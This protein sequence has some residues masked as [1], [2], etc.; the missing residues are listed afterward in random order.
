MSTAKRRT[1]CAGTL[2]TAVSQRISKIFS[3]G[4]WQTL[5]VCPS[6]SFCLLSSCT[7]L[8]PRFLC[9]CK[10]NNCN[11]PH[12]QSAQLQAPSLKICQR[13][14]SL[15][16]ISLQKTRDATT[17]AAWQSLPQSTVFTKDTNNLASVTRWTFYNLDPFDIFWAQTLWC[18]AFS[19]HFKV[20][21]I[22]ESRHHVEAFIVL[23]NI[24]YIK[25]KLC[26][27]SKVLGDAN[28]FVPIFTHS[29]QSQGNCHSF[30]L[31]MAT[32]R[33]FLCFVCI[34]TC[35]CRGKVWPD[36]KHLKHLKHLFQTLGQQHRL[37]NSSKTRLHGLTRRGKHETFEIKVTC[38]NC[39]LW[40]PALIFALKSSMMRL[41]SSVSSPT[42][43]VLEPP[44]QANQTQQLQDALQ[45]ITLKARKVKQINNTRR[46]LEVIWSHGVTS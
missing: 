37:A 43:K 2:S 44:P 22:S 40:P 24:K 21:N 45:K 3:L 32:E 36:R 12:Q 28:G 13:D 7:F 11:W 42:T 16:C 34:M 41:S 38:E 10:R 1:Q 5:P 4:N 19:R 20:Q 39:R 9:S 27:N 26:T 17:I 29:F 25:S 15:K 14:L 31:R 35:R 23:P 8:C 33:L 46:K 6:I 18:F 30:L